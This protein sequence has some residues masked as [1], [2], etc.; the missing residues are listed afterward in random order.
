M[1]YAAQATRDQTD[2]PA[3][4]G[5]RLA[6]AGEGQTDERSDDEADDSQQQT[7]CKDHQRELAAPVIVLPASSEEDAPPQDAGQQVM[8]ALSGL[9]P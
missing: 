3:H 4:V 5:Q 8:A 6:G 9:T 2:W 1:L 7:R